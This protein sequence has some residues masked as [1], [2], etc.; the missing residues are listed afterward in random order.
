VQIENCEALRSSSS[1]KSVFATGTQQDWSDSWQSAAAYGALESELSCLSGQES[2]CSGKISY[3]MTMSG[4]S[5]VLQTRGRI[6]KQIHFVPARW[7][8]LAT[9]LNRCLCSLIRQCFLKTVLL[10][11]THDMIRQAAACA[12]SPKL[13]LQV[14]AVLSGSLASSLRRRAFFQCCASYGSGY[15]SPLR[16]RGHLPLACRR[17]TSIV[18][19]ERPPKRLYRLCSR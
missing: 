10:R 3:G 7:K 2:A 13:K 19:R 12:F 6:N 17:S 16:W 5:T 9:C 1:Q 14:G 4:S 15:H 11:C 18:N 8:S